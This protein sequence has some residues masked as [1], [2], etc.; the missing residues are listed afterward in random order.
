MKRKDWLLAAAGLALGLGAAW[1]IVRFRPHTFHGTV[2][3]TPESVADFDLVSS[4]GQ[5]VSLH[6][7]RGKLVL[8]YFGY[9]SCPDVCPATLAEL[10]E[11]LDALG[12]KA[13]QVQVIMVSVDPEYDTPEVLAEYLAQFDPRFLGAT[14]TPEEIAE[15]AGA[16]GIY[17]EEVVEPKAADHEHEETPAAGHH[18]VDHTVATLVLD[19][20]GR[21]MLVYRF[22]V[23]GAE[24]ASDLA[25]ILR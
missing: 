18:L 13:D 14:G 6:D 9:T 25:Y 12:N 20:Q 19:Q 15:V 2:I 24:M 5:R 10:A 1:A 4:T 11:A 22:G 7:F 21:L 16:Y 23:T 8:L 17:Y 3:P